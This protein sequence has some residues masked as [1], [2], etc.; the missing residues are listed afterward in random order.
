MS[1]NVYLKDEVRQ[2]EGFEERER[3]DKSQKW[4]EHRIS[5]MYLFHDKG[6]W[7]IILHNLTDQIPESVKEL[8]EEISCFEA[9][10][11]QPK[12]ALGIYKLEDVEAELDDWDRGKYQLKMRGKSMENML[13]LYRLIRAGKT[14][15]AESYD[16]KQ[17]GASRAELEAELEQMRKMRQTAMRM[18]EETNADLVRLNTDLLAYRQELANSI[19]LFCAK[20]TV[21]REIAKILNGNV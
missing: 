2:V 5:G 19:W 3:I 21:V 12:R 18:W 1:I 13:Q 17:S 11:N 8:V 15:P 20:A 14:L 4:N 9:F 6:R 7:Y 10:S 16:G